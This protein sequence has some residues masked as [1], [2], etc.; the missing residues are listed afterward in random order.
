MPKLNNLEL[1]ALEHVILDRKDFPILVNL[2]I[3]TSLPNHKLVYLDSA[4]T[5]LKPNVMLAAVQA[6]DTIYTANLHR[7]LYQQA[8][9]VTSKYEF[10]R[11][12]V[13]NFIGAQVS[14]I[15]FTAG[16]TAGINFVATSW[17]ESNLKPG[18]ELIVTELEHHANFLPWLELAK[19]KQVSLKI[20]PI[21][22]V[23]GELDLENFRKL[24]SRKTKLIAVSL[25]SNVLGVPTSA[26]ELI[27]LAKSY[28]P[29]IKI[30][31]DAAQTIS[32]AK[33]NVQELDC[34]F[35]VFSGHKIFAP[36]GVG[37]LFMRAE[38]GEKLEPYQYGGGMVF[39]LN[40]N[41]ASWLK[42]PYKFEAGTPPIAQVIGLGA[43][44]EYLNNLNFGKLQAHLANLCTVL[45][46]NLAEIPGIK[47]LGDPEKIK[48]SGHIVSFSSDKYH[49]HDIAAFLDRFGICVRAG[50]HCA[51]LL[52]QRLGV[53]SSVRVSLHGYNNLREINYFIESLRQLF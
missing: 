43:A 19:R 39:D 17:G 5:S 52:H 2:K 45:I 6:Y 31:V 51:K 25:S 49:A 15:I 50:N 9:L 48:T 10:V 24:L 4:A 37:V 27:K 18:D 33:I 40:Y 30:L 13:A 36:T 16:T 42:A 3:N 38:I 28:N 8:E 1:A 46:N 11:A 21:D 44:L 32:H 23:T 35:L 41:N 12:Q 29:E 22:P 47:I 20:V 26:P 34:D 14:E 53:E 7:G